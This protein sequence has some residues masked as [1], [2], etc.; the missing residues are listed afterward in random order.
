[1]ETPLLA[2]S[3]NISQIPKEETA[4]RI[5]SLKEQCAPIE[6]HVAISTRLH[7]TV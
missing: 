3:H 5:I 2:P 4:A 7:E 6:Y 1:M